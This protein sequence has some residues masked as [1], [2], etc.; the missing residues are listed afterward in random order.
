MKRTGRREK[1]LYYKRQ[2][3]PYILLAPILLFVSLFLLWPMINVFVMSVQEY[4]LLK[5]DERHF[6]GFQNFVTV[7]R[8]V[9]VNL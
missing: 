3:T 6:I 9:V 4:R 7:F 8:L 2:A 1:Y 5:P